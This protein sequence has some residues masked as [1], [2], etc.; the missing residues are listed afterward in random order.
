MLLPVVGGRRGPRRARARAPR[1]PPRSPRSPEGDGAHASGRGAEREERGW[2]A[3]GS[4]VPPVRTVRAR[5][6]RSLPRFPVFAV[7]ASAASPCASRACVSLVAACRV[8]SPRSPSPR[9]RS[10]DRGA[11]VTRPSSGPGIRFWRRGPVTSLSGAA[12]GETAV[13]R[14]R[15]VAGRVGARR[16][17]RSFGGGGR[18]CLEGVGSVRVGKEEE[19]PARF[20][21]PREGKRLSGRR[22]RSAAVDG[23]S[24]GRGASGDSSGPVVR[25]PGRALA[26]HVWGTAIRAGLGA[27]RRDTPACCVPALLRLPAAGAPVD[28]SPR[29]RGPALPSVVGPRCAPPHVPRGGR[30]STWSS[31]LSLPSASPRRVSEHARGPAFFH[32]VP[33]PS[34]SASRPGA[35]A[36]RFSRRARWR[37]RR[38]PPRRFPVSPDPARR[39]RDHPVLPGVAPRCRACVGGARRGPTPAPRAPARGRR[40]GTSAWS[41][42]AVCR[43]GARAVWRR[44]GGSRRV[45]SPGSVRPPPSS[46]RVPLVRPRPVVVRALSLPP[47]ACRDLWGIPVGSHGRPPSP[48]AVL[49]SSSARVSVVI[50]IPALRSLARSVLPASLDGR[51]SVRPTIASQLAL[52]PG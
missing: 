39:V 22:P 51:P 35:A 52:L 19:A 40:P 7:P 43:A 15:R 9:Q 20:G 21:E 46:R 17:R 6:E 24:V 11:A 41:V 23:G 29:P 47:A 28:D 37:G 16:R 36:V 50:I 8:E 4:R 49:V 1:D 34:A 10:H 42:G 13:G 2:V 12:F 48:R 30:P 26:S 45:A 27:W 5:R 3:V 44:L 38:R 25:P 14:L 18:V 33:V 31:P 32:G